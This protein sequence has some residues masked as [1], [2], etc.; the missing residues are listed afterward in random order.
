LVENM[1]LFRESWVRVKEVVFEFDMCSNEGAE[2]FSVGESI[3]MK[4]GALLEKWDDCVGYYG[5]LKGS[6]LDILVRFRRVKDGS[7]GELC[8]QLLEGFK[9]I[10]G[11]CVKGPPVVV[12]PSAI[13]CPVVGQLDRVIGFHPRERWLGVGMGDGW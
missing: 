1:G 5:V 6:S 10:G 7:G 11:E 13:Y 8:G 9:S 2:W 4:V 3:D 12:N